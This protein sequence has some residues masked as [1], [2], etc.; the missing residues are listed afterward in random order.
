MSSTVI[1]RLAKAAT[2]LA[3]AGS[4]AVG[5]AGTAAASSN[6]TYGDPVAAGKY[7][8]HQ[9]YDDCAIMSSADAIGQVT[10]KTP[11]EEAIIKIAETTPS[12]THAGSIYIKPADTSHPNSGNGTMLEDLPTLLKQYKVDSVISDKDAATKTGIKA[13]MEGIEQALSGHHAVIV[14]L[15]AEMI[16]HQ[17]VTN[18][19]TNGDPRADHAVVVT[20][21]DLANNIVHLNDSGIADGKDEKV[22]L[23]LFLKAWDTGNEELVVTK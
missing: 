23:D 9:H 14:A 2:L 19:Y 20:G 12:A 1:S 5:M 13:G 10:G 6:A 3:V 18:K 22:A 15:N 16:W 17:T 21:V 11:A 4:L 8:S 7:W